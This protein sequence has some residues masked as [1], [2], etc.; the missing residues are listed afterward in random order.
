MGCGNTAAA[1]QGQFVARVWNAVVIWNQIIPT[2]FLFI[3][4]PP[5]FFCSCTFSHTFS[6]SEV[7]APMKSHCFAELLGLNL[8]GVRYSVLI[9]CSSP[10]SRAASAEHSTLLSFLL[11]GTPQGQMIPLRF[12]IS[13]MSASDK[14]S[15]SH[16]LSVTPAHCIL[17]AV[18]QAFIF[19]S[20]SHTTS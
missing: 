1:G 5:F 15:P 4:H 7:P 6:R 8:W 9:L 11:S 12:W 13:I 14:P 18:Q 16:S 3:L 2:L 17:Q 19:L 10:H 20:N